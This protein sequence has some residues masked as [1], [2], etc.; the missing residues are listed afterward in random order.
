MTVLCSLN[1]LD[2]SEL[3]MLQEGKIVFSSGKGKAT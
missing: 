3:S 1:F 2:H